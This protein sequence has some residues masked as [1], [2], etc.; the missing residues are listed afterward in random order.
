MA[1]PAQQGGQ[2]DNSVGIIWGVVAGLVAIG[3]LWYSFKDSIMSMYLILKLYEINFL[4]Y[5]SSRFDDLRVTTLAALADTSKLN[6]SDLIAIGDRVGDWLRIPFVIIL[7][8]LAFVVYL[9][10]SARTFRHNYTMEELAKLEANN[11]PQISPTVG[12]GLLKKDIDSGPWAMAMPPMQFCKKNKLLE[13]VRP[14]KREG[15]SR[16]EWDKV[17]VVL[18]RGEANKIFALQLGQLWKGVDKLAPHIKA[19]FAVF[20]ARI[21]AD[22]QE[23]AKLIRQL[24]ESCTTK[25]N[26][27]G[28]D[29]LLKKHINTK[30]IQHIIQ[31]HAYVLTVMAAMLESARDDGVQAS[32]DFL[33]LKPLDRRLWYTLNMVGRQTPFVEV[34][35]VFAHWIAEKEAGR[36]LIVPTVEEAT[37]ALEIALSEVVYRPD[38]EESK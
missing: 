20:A 8:L 11:W 22:S 5:F 31:S 6:F 24:N 13:E 23:A 17:Q 15:I 21:N 1:A 35:G 32:A 7:F 36:K 30:L 2:P 38:E 18:K 29:T 28:V 10:N 12:L 26:V 16:K 19:L 9:S 34:A 25:L 3:V 27:S 33:W 37:K 4:S 14:Q